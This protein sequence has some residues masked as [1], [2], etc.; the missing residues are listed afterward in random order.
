MSLSV[1]DHDDASVIQYV[2]GRIIG[3]H[4]GPVDSVIPL[5]SSDFRER[6]ASITRL[7]A[8]DLA[9][10]ALG[11]GPARLCASL[12]SPGAEQENNVKNP[13]EGGGGG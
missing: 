5:P 3:E 9:T 2:E 6:S 10:R 7:S 11:C 4:L 1:Y 13:W 8:L 12:G